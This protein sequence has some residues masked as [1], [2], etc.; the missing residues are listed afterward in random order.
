[1][2]CGRGDGLLGVKAGLETNVPLET[3]QFDQARLAL[4]TS[5]VELK[6]RSPAA[7]SLAS[8]RMELAAKA[9]AGSTR[10]QLRSERSSTSPRR[11]V[12][13]G[14]AVEARVALIGGR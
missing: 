7:A 4:H 8:W 10:L 6:L 14:P 3:Q 1:M 13:C 11:P 2:G 5:K 9:A 12:S